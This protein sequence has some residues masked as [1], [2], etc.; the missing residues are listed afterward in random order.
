MITGIYS[1]QKLSDEATRRADRLHVK[2]SR[3]DDGWVLEGLP[4]TLTQ[5]GYPSL[6]NPA[7]PGKVRSRT[8][9]EAD[10]YMYLCEQRVRD[11][12]RPQRRDNDSFIL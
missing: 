5:L 10:H 8:L 6:E 9:R 2:L 4:F 11:S 7:A 12:Q 3:C 1:K